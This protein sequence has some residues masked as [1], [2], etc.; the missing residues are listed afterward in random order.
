MKHVAQPTL[1]IIDLSRDPMWDLGDMATMMKQR[2][3]TTPLQRPERFVDVFHFD[4]VY[5]SW[6]SIGGYR[7][8][9]WF[10]YRRSENIK[11]HPLKSLASDDPLKALRLLCRDMRGRYPSKMIGYRDFKLIVGQV[12]AALDGI[13]EYR[14][15]RIRALSLVLLHKGRIKTACLKSNGSTS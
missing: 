10:V 7:Y 2:R 12:V 8:A 3:N 6:T 5:G 14:E 11:K 9:L 13:N 4:N 1:K 15:I